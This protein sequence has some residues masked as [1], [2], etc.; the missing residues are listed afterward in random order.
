MVSG[1]A[2]S[3]KMKQE[4]DLKKLGFVLLAILVVWGVNYYTDFDWRSMSIQ[5]VQKSDSALLKAGEECMAIS[6]QATAHLI[7]KVEF[8]KLEFAA[9]KANV[10]AR[11]M[12]DKQFRQNPAWLDYAKK[13]A[14]H[15]AAAQQISEDEALETL[16]RQD[17]L[18]F[19][20]VKEKPIY[21]LGITPAQ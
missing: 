10:F 17:M 7:P 3:H 14:I 4:D 6:D 5:P 8:Q 9:R 2:F 19:K 11:C 16:K 15:D 12:G 20:P 21:W 13:K 1:S 18:Q